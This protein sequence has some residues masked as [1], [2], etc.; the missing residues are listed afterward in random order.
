MRTI[1]AAFETASLADVIRPILLAELEFASST[2]R[3]WS[4]IGTLS[5]NSQ[6]WIGTGLLGGVTP[7]EEAED[8][9]AHG[10]RFVMSGIPAEVLELCLAETRQ[11]KKGRLWLGLLDAAETVIVD[12]VLIFDGLLD[13]PQI[14]EQG[15]TATITISAESRQ[16]R[17]Q[18]PSGRRYT[19]QDQQ[20]DFPGD[21]GFEFV[22]RLQDKDFTWGGK[23][24]RSDPGPK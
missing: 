3:V 12:P 18:R 16:A 4:G 9:S 19:D 13:V 20:I 23:L 2:L 10:I 6:S 22:A 1:T 8:I 17:L 5:W 11:G 21:R 7:V 14:D 24:I 15:E